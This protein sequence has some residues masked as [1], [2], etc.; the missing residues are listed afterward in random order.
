MFLCRIAL[1]FLPG[2][3]VLVSPISHLMAELEFPN[4]STKSSQK[5]LPKLGSKP[6]VLQ[7]G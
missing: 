1:H 6:K 2:T 5:D 7:S 4:Y 3:Y